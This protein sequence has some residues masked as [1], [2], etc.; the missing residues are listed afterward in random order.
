MTSDL[1]QAA[2]RAAMEASR[3]QQVAAAIVVV[4][5]DGRIV[6]SVRDESVGAINLDVATR[7]AVAAATF[8][9]STQAILEGVKDDMAAMRATIADPNLSLLAGGMPI[10]RDGAVCGALGI[11]GGHYSQDQT[12]AVE[13]LSAVSRAHA[14][15]APS[16]DGEFAGKRAIITGALGGI[17]LET[18]ALLAAAGAKV[19]G[20]DL[21]PDEGGRTT[22]RFRAEGR[23]VTFETLDV[24]DADAIAKLGGALGLSWGHVDILVNNA[25][26]LS[27]SP[28]LQTAPAEWDH[29]QSVNCRSAFLMTRAVAP[30]MGGEGV[31]LNM[32]SSAAMSPTANAAAYSVAK[33][34]IVTLSR[35]SALELGPGIRVNAVCPG[36]LDTAMPRNYLRGH[37]K[38][39]EIMGSMI[40]R[41]I[42]KRLGQASEIA[43]LLFFPA[44]AKAAFITGAVISA[45]GGFIA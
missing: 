16:A 32:S 36:P 20:L 8:A 26:V 2:I 23:D 22:A 9:T 18:C 33:M 24:S 14:A 41:T 43:E 19:L 37:P 39:R 45:D 42:V 17:G 12:I 15:A 38:E 3:R 25:G 10:R 1:A 44:S 28:L 34:G 30:L 7:K 31:I 6:A 13:A 4:D 27:F 29:V 40:E 11:A 35:I 21:Q 5:S